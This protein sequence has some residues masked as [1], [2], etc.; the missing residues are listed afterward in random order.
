MENKCRTC[1][2][3]YKGE[4]YSVDFR[5]S[6]SQKTSESAFNNLTESGRLSEYIQESKQDEIYTLIK[7]AFNNLK[8]LGHLKKSTDKIKDI[9]EIDT[10]ELFTQSCIETIDDIISSFVLDSLGADEGTE[11]QT[12]SDFCCKFWE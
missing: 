1:H 3:Y 6:I 2:N 11:F 7:I 9:S 5:K 4:C 8:A 10:D 12:D